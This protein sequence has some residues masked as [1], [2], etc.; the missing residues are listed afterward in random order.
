MAYTNHTIKVDDQSTGI[1]TTKRVTPGKKMQIGVQDTT[2]DAIYDVIAYIYTE[3]NKATRLKHV[4]ETGLTGS[5]FKTSLA[6]FVEL[7]IEITSAS[8]G[9]VE[10]EILQCSA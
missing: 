7:G 4:I 9:D 10:C 3:D 6:G 1:Y 2:N 8:T 5:Y